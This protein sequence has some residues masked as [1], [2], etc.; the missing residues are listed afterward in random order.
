MAKPI[1]RMLRRGDVEVLTGLSRSQIYKQMALGNF[2]RPVFPDGAHA[3]RW[4]EREVAAWQLKQI[5]AR[6]AKKV[7]AKRRAA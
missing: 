7:P 2:P 4:L 3:A 5:A 1:Q 6:D